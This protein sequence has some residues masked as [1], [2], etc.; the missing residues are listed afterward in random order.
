MAI[1]KPT[2]WALP[3]SVL[4]PTTSPAALSNGPPELPG[5]IAASVCSSPVRVG[6]W[7]G[8]IVRSRA[9]TMPAETVGE[10]ASM[11]SALPIATTGFADLEVR[12]APDRDRLQAGV[13]GDTQQREIVVGGLADDLGA[14]EAAVAAGDDDVGGALGDVE[15][16]EH[17]A[18]VVDDDPGAHPLRNELGLLEVVDAN[19]ELRLGDRD[20]ALAH[21]LH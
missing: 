13:V 8:R 18:G 16:R 5:L 15:V 4:M 3:P 7:S 1:A 6:P 11:P 14:A 19:H 17:V 10:V 2:L 12:A 20:H 9:E 21:L